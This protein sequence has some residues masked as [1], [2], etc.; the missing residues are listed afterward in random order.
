MSDEDTYLTTK[1]TIQWLRKHAVFDNKD[2]VV[3]HKFLHKLNETC[4]LLP[5]KTSIFGN[6]YS[7][8]HLKQYVADVK[9]R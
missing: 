8:K 1:Q 3:D 6:K 5:D 7:L 9:P 2:L 4:R